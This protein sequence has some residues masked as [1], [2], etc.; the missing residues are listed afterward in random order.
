MSAA[1]AAGEMIERP[2]RAM[3][4]LPVRCST[5]SDNTPPVMQH[6]AGIVPANGSRSSNQPGEGDIGPAL[7]E[8]DLVSCMAALPPT[9][10]HRLRGVMQPL[11][12]SGGL[13]GRV[14]KVGAARQPWA[15]CCKPVGLGPRLVTELH[16]HFAESAKLEQ[17]ISDAP[18]DAEREAGWLHAG[19]PQAVREAAE[20]ELSDEWR[21]K[22][23]KTHRLTFSKA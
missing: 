2:C 15:E 11:Q 18:D 22:I 19:E 23:Q 5:A 14:P 10:L 20:A 1:H 13:W 17:V 6:M 16:T 4:S 21:V 3:R 9:G 12:G 7:I 8:A